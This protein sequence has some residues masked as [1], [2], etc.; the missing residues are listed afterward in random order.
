MCPARHRTYGDLF[1]R[2][3]RGELRD[4]DKPLGPLELS[5]KV[6]QPLYAPEWSRLA[7]DLRTLTDQPAH[8]PI[9]LAP[10]QRS[11][12]PIP[13]PEI[14][15]CSDKSRATYVLPVKKPVRIAEDLTT[16]SKARIELVV[17]L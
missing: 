12:E 14:A 11:G 8:D 4:A 16:G 13:M 10:V 9:Q 7:T 2:A 5:R 1:A 6:T 3:G 17:V 15:L